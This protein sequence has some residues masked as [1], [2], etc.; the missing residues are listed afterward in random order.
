MANP[1]VYIH[2]PTP[3]NNTKINFSKQHTKYIAQN[4]N[5]YQKVSLFL[6]EIR[7]LLNAERFTG[8]ED[9]VS[10]K[11]DKTKIMN[12]LTNGLIGCKGFW[13]D[14]Q[15][16]GLN[17]ASIVARFYRLD[18]QQCYSNVNYLKQRLLQ[19]LPD[20]NVTVIKN[21]NP[22]PQEIEDA[23]NESEKSLE[24]QRKD[25]VIQ[26]RRSLL[27]TLHKV[28]TFKEF[29]KKI[30]HLPIH[31]SPEFEDDENPIR[32]EIYEEAMQLSERL[33]NLKDVCLSIKRDHTDKIIK[34]SHE[35]QSNPIVIS[36]MQQLRTAYQR[37]EF[38][39]QIHSYDEITQLMNK[40]LQKIADKKSIMESLKRY[41]DKYIEVTVDNTLQFKAGKSILFLQKYCF[42]HVFNVKKPYQLKKVQFKGLTAF[43]YGFNEFS[44]RSKKTMLLK[45]KR[46]NARTG[47][48]VEE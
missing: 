29:K 24:E 32:M 20:A 8:F 4:D 48:L 40:G 45:D 18:T 27:L 42:I 34:L 1:P 5:T 22:L 17:I 41:T 36:V 12:G 31:E 7:V 14:N 3:I 28:K 30:D 38:K 10:T 26:V 37:K 35:Y 39:E 6:K 16:I 21:G 15:T 25:A 47:Q 9:I 46:Y 13:S 23:F 44:V 33:D 2:L 11:I 19:F 43:G